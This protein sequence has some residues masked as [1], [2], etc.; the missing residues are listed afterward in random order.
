MRETVGDIDLLVTSDAPE[1]VMRAFCGLPLVARI[2][3]YGPTKSSIVTTKGVQVD[4]RVV[5]PAVWGAALMYFTGSKP[6]NIRLRNIAARAGLNWSEYGLFDVESGDQLAAETEEEV[7]ARLGLPWIEPTL[8]E[9]R[10]EIE[11]AL[12]GALPRVVHTGDIRGDL[13][14]TRT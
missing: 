13:H 10:G 14:T 6:H 11:A 5:E 2:L 4:L 7:Y 9:D 3:A 8:R 1:A 12:A